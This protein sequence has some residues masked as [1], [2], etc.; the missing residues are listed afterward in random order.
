MTVLLTGGY[1]VLQEQ[2]CGLVL[3][4]TARFHTRVETQKIA[5]S[6]GRDD[7]VS[8]SIDHSH[9]LPTHLE[10][11][12]TSS[13]C[14]ADHVQSQTSDRN[15]YVEETLVATMNGLLGLDQAVLVEHLR[16]MQ[17]Q[18]ERLHVLLQADNDF[19]SQV[20]RLQAANQCLCREH[21]RALPPFLPPS[22]EQQADGSLVAAKTG[23]GSS[24][25]LITSLVAALMA[26]FLP[27]LDLA[28]PGP[29]LYL[30]H[31][32]AQLCHCFVQRKIG[33]GFD[34]STACF[35]SQ[36]YTRF[37]RSLLDGFSHEDALL[38]SKIAA[39]VSD[40][41][42]WACDVRVQ[43]FRLP[44]GLRLLMGDIS[45]GSATVSLVRQVLNWQQ[46]QPEES[47]RL[48]D[49]LHGF[50]Q[51]VAAG[52]DALD[53]ALQADPA[54]HEKRVAAADVTS[55]QWLEI[56]ATIGALLLKTR[57]AFV[58][59]RSSLRNMGAQA[60]VPIEPPSQ[61]DLLDATM[62]LP[63]VLAAGVPGA[64]GFDAVFVLVLD[65]SVLPRVEAFWQSYASSASSRIC[66]LLCDV[67]V[68]NLGTGL[69]RE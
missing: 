16:A 27:T 31:N 28:R 45:A 1:L 60:G 38:P 50:N 61:T 3:A 48:M 54:L 58:Q 26:F 4:T 33:S 14:A 20:H 29:D 57:E 49:A 32:M 44:T 36:R 63:G 41:E 30:I 42:R 2:Y 40:H 12:L 22:M 68:T 35:G 19:Y 46:E 23:M 67:A 56:N 11:V 6:N 8:Q 13:T 25:A 18:Q 59:V 65:A 43:P 53:H 7:D 10:P 21:L 9:A 47:K 24:A 17:Q 64:G 39:C 52:L 51:R 66:P 62:A 37:P 15:A 34:V 55:D 69:V 5:A